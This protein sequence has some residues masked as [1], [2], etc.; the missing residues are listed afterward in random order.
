[1]TG[2]RFVEGGR[3]LL[4]K[5]NGKDM[6]IF[7]MSVLLAFS[8]WLLHNLSQR[9]SQTIRVPVS[10]VCNI[11]GHSPNSSNIAVVQ[12]RCRTTGFQIMKFNNLA[13]DKNV[14]VEF[15]PQ[16][17]HPMGDDNYYI[18]SNELTA[19][20]PNIFGPES[21]LEGF[22]TDT[23]V[24]RFPPEN[25][26]KIPVLPVYRISFDSQYTSTSDLSVS[27]DSVTVYGEP[28]LIDNL[29]RISTEAFSLQN[30]RRSV[31]GDVK[32]EK[33]KGV[34]FSQDKVDYAV[35]VARFVEIRAEIP[36]LGRN[37]PSDRML[38][39]YPSTATVSFRCAFPVTV[40]PEQSTRLYIDYNDFVNSLSGKCIPS[41]QGV[42]SDI[43]GYKIEPEVFDC[44]ESMR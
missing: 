41:V 10:A 23:L 27:P 37:V 16:D 39:I 1:M 40:E 13:S 25:S 6:V 35:D 32:L 11:E 14:R 15:N 26:K 44:V 3:T 22:M 43:F 2:G 33:I 30:L 4:G 18:T 34:R 28:Y 38:I 8:I 12:A 24:F 29:S 42:P 9:Y 20:A 19:Y 17:M 5:V 36:V 21:T 7:I 31:R